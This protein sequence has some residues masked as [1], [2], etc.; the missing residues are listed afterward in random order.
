MHR[1]PAPHDRD[2]T[3]KLIKLLQSATEA[4]ESDG[5]Y[6]EAAGLPPGFA[7]LPMHVLLNLLGGT[8]ALIAVVNDRKADAD[9]LLAALAALEAIEG[10]ESNGHDDRPYD[11][12]SPEGRALARGLERCL[13][14]LIAEG[15]ESVEAAAQ[16]LLDRLLH[17]WPD[18]QP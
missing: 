16:R 13:P 18:V 14:R 10:P 3:S 17:C 6:D 1:P 5:D 15:E 7:D 4:A 9:S 12:P 8:D 11:E 2:F